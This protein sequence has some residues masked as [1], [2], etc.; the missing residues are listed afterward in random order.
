MGRGEGGGDRRDGS[1]RY[2]FTHKLSAL[3]RRKTFVRDHRTLES[4]QRLYMSN[5]QDGNSH[6]MEPNVNPDGD[7][8]LI[9]MLGGDG[10][11]LVEDKLTPLMSTSHACSTAV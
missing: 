8:T 7:W 10:R 1:A 4:K 9:R 6:T 11:D 3:C 2:P 5:M